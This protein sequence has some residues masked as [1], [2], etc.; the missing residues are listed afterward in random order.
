MVDPTTHWFTQAAHAGLSPIPVDTTTKRPLVRWA[1]YQ[2]QPADE[3]TL[4]SWGAAGRNI[5][6]VCG[7]VSGRLICIDIEAT[8]MGQLTELSKR[9]D[10]TGLKELFDT[11]CEGY[12]ETT[13]RGGLHILIRLEGEG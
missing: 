2:E 9:L 12:T 13:A 7:R 11:W 10:A 1:T 3:L 5:G 6:I 8:F 4:K